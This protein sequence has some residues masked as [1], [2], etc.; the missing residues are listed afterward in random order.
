MIW[1]FY[2]QVRLNLIISLRNVYGQSLMGGPLS[3]WPLI[4]YNSMRI[5]VF[6]KKGHWHS[7]KIHYFLSSLIYLKQVRSVCNTQTSIVKCIFLKIKLKVYLFS[8]SA[9][10]INFKNFL[11]WLLSIPYVLF[12]FQKRSLFNWQHLRTHLHAMLR[13]SILLVHLVFKK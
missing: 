1:F 4:E 5:R 9:S 8:W 6:E 13:Y 10:G 12:F 3:D 2:L 7:Q 11:Q